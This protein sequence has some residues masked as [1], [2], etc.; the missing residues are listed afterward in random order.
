VYEGS[1]GYQLFSGWWY[2]RRQFPD[3]VPPIGPSDRIELALA[4]QGLTWTRDF[5]VADVCR[6]PRLEHADSD[7]HQ[8]ALR[9]Y[10]DGQELTQCPLRRAVP[11]VYARGGLV[12]AT[13]SVLRWLPSRLRR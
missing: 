13:R 11:P 5:C 1:E 7:A 3:A 10:V 9:A 12:A 8:G 6:G 4:G 2:G